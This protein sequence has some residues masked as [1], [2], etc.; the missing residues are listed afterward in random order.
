MPS[1]DCEKEFREFWC[2]LLFGVCD[3][4]G[5][6]RLPSFEL[7]DSLQTETCYNLIQFA[8]SVPEFS[9]VVQNCNNF[10]IGDPPPCSK[11]S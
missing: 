10:R 4:S 11:Y 2:L 9:V 3:D 8:A 6:T 1:Q 5:R 7:C